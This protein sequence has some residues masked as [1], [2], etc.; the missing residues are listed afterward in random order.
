MVDLG[1]GGGGVTIELARRL[2]AGGGAW[3]LVGVDA[4]PACVE[5]AEKA[6]AGAGAGAGAG[7][8]AR[9]ARPSVA[10]EVARV[11]ED[12]G[13]LADLRPDVVVSS[14]FLHHLEDE[15]LD[16]VLAACARHAR[17]AVVMDDLRRDRRSLALV[18]VGVRV[19]SRCPVVHVD[20]PRSVRAALTPAELRRR[21]E[22]AGLAGARVR[23]AGPARM[24]LAW[25]RPSA[26]ATS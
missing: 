25:R 26:E 24:R 16:A 6:L 14:L 23:S 12:D 3:R 9:D 15:P 18:R 19:L 1:C 2:A 11:G 5:A 22:A 7:D 17:R 13:L 4:S 21:A 10:F 8:G 20:G